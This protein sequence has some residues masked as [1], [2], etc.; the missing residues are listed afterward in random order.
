MKKFILFIAVLTASIGSGYAEEFTLDGTATS[1]SPTNVP[2]IVSTTAQH[3]QMIYP[4]SLLKNDD[5]NDNVDDFEIVFIKKMTFYFNGTLNLEN[6]S[7]TI[8][9]ATADKDNYSSGNSYSEIT[10]L[11]NCT[12]VFQ[13]TAAASNTN[14]KMDINNSEHKLTI[15]F[16]QRYQCNFNNNYGLLIDIVVNNIAPENSSVASNGDDDIND[17]S[18]N[19]FNTTSS[20]SIYGT[21]NTSTLNSL[22]KTTFDCRRKITA[23]INEGST[24]HEF[25][26]YTEC[27]REE[28][29]A[30]LKKYGG[31][32]YSSKSEYYIYTSTDYQ[33]PDL[34]DKGIQYYLY[35]VPDN[36]NYANLK[37]QVRGIGNTAFENTTFAGENV[38]LILPETIT[39]IG[40][41]NGTENKCFNFTKNNNQQFIIIINRTDDNK[42]LPTFKGT[43]NA[44]NNNLV[45]SDTKLY[46]S[47]NCS[48]TFND[49]SWLQAKSKFSEI[50]WA[51]Y[52]YKMSFFYGYNGQ[53]KNITEDLN[54]NEQDGKVANIQNAPFYNHPLTIQLNENDVEGNTDGTFHHYNTF[55]NNCF[56]SDDNA[57]L[58]TNKNVITAEYN[59][60]YPVDYYLHTKYYATLEAGKGLHYY[61]EGDNLGRNTIFKDCDSLIFRYKNDT[62][63]PEWDYRGT[64][65]DHLTTNVDIHV[66]K[67]IDNADYHYFS[68]PF[69]CKVSDIAVTYVNANQKPTGATDNKIPLLIESLETTEKFDNDYFI[70][71][72]YQHQKG[73]DGNTT[74]ET[75]VYTQITDIN[76]TLQANKGYAF[77]IVES[78][79][80]LGTTVE[81][82]VV[83]KSGTEEKILGSSGEQINETNSLAYKGYKIKVTCES[84]VSDLNKGWNMVGNPFYHPIKASSYGKY[85]AKINTALNNKKVEHIRTDIQNQKVQPFEAIFIQVNSAGTITIDPTNQTVPTENTAAAFSDGLI[86]EH[87]SVMIMSPDSSSDRTTVINVEGRTEDVVLEDDMT[88]IFNSGVQIYSLYSNT[89]CVFKELPLREDSLYTI[90]LGVVIPETGNYTF[91]LDSSLTMFWGSALLHDKQASLYY[92]LNEDGVQISLN[93]GEDSSRFEILV[94][95]SDIP[96]DLE[97]VETSETLDAYVH[98]GRLFVENIADGSTLSIYDISGRLLYNAPASGDFN[99][100]F[101]THG[102]YMVVLRGN[103]T[104]SIKVVY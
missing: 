81:A 99:Y 33:S 101:N 82:N 28:N 36:V 26:I 88:K 64:D 89:P 2:F 61:S 42:S 95:P 37:P 30:V 78:D 20:Q 14:G 27:D 13:G 16:S 24:I 23:H 40:E 50:G 75:A 71:Q 100:Q 49:E 1:T 9:L 18:W 94:I 12:T 76:A 63:I 8:N 68:L 73:A 55:G 97:N 62:E 67:K 44:D 103:T 46:V 45:P 104:G 60:I 25:Y 84:D 72:E 80:H 3:I 48:K 32:V 90:P 17:F 59:G 83:F 4:L 86:P 41:D 96:S 39:E 35:I 6:M 58:N 56:P 29:A 69:N 10:Q 5:Q 38:A 65:N 57:I 53:Q 34:T 11:Q 93:Q 31:T 91:A 47:S 70:I 51:S 19:H 54:G 79:G 21:D 87:L 66:E 43:L 52:P 22:P 92:P 102:V 74:D 77:A 7:F 15:E 98:D 85:I